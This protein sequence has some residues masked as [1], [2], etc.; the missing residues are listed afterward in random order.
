MKDAIGDR[1]K[2]NYENRSRIS[3]PRRSYTL[4]RVDGKAFH[5][6]TRGLIRP[7]DDGLILDMDTTAAYLCKHIMG[8]KLAIVQSD[9]ISVLLTD[10]EELG[11][12]AWFDNNLQKICSVSASMATAKFNESRLHR[13]LAAAKSGDI[14]LDT[15]KW[16]EF[17]SRVFQIPQRT[18]VENYFIWRQQD[19]TRNSIAAVAQSLYSHKELQGK[20]SDEQQELIFQKGINWNDFA[21]KYKRGR[22]IMKETFEK[23]PDA[24]DEKSKSSIRSRWVSVGA[25]IFTQ[26]R[27]FLKNLIL[28]NI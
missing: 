10:F 22:V 26:E 1:M 9:E 16:A 7:F 13:H 18:E 27:D 11:A 4:I 21:P 20:T 15:F 24:T 25:P 23:M 3:L 2:E 19:T 5:T 12:D 28:E 17:D 8:A 6:Y 14:G